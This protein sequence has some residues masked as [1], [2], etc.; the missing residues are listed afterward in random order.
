MFLY[1]YFRLSGEN[2]QNYLNF[3]NIFDMQHWKSGKWENSFFEKEI[4]SV[5]LKN[6]WGN[7]CV[8]VDNNNKEDKKI[9]SSKLPKK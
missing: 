2:A 7:Y 6:Y 3:W 5:L 4:S 1:G 9:Y 8:I